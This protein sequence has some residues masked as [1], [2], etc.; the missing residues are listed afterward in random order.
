[1][2]SITFVDKTTVV[3]ASWLNDVNN[4]VYS[5]LGM[6][7][8]SI[9][10]SFTGTVGGIKNFLHNP[11]LSVAQR[12]ITGSLAANTGT[13][14]PDRWIVYSAGSTASWNI[15]TSG[16]PPFSPSYLYLGGATGNTGFSISQRL[17]AIDCAPLVGKTVTLSLAADCQGSISTLPIT[18]SIYAPTSVDNWPGGYS[19]IAT[20]TFATINTLWSRYSASFVIPTSAVNGLQIKIGRAHV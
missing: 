6:V 7:A 3:P 16:A 13:Y 14:C 8:G 9:P 10:P 18:Y 19:S 17:E 2:S 1:M 20:G 11:G 12:G 15:G 4:A 5:G